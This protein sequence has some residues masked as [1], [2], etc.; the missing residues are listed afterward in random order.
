MTIVNPFTGNT[1]NDPWYDS[2]EV[3]PINPSYIKICCNLMDQNNSLIYKDPLTFQMKSI[4]PNDVNTRQIY[5][6]VDKDL[7]Y[8]NVFGGAYVIPPPRPV[9]STARELEYQQMFNTQN[10]KIMNKNNLNNL[11]S[12]I[13][14][15]YPYGLPLGIGSVKIEPKKV[16]DNTELTPI[17]AD[18]NTLLLSS[19]EFDEAYDNGDIYTDDDGNYFEVD[20]D[21]PVRIRGTIRLNNFVNKKRWIHVDGYYWPVKKINVSPIDNCPNVAGYAMYTDENNNEVKNV[22]VKNLNNIGVFNL[23]DNEILKAIIKHG[24]AVILNTKES[25]EIFGKQLVKKRMMISEKNIGGYEIANIIPNYTC[26]KDGIVRDIIILKG[27]L[28]YK[29]C[30]SDIKIVFPFANSV[31]KGIIPAKDKTLKVGIKAKIINDKNL[32]IGKGEIVTIISIKDNYYANSD[33]NQHKV[34]TVADKGGNRFKVW[35][36]C[37]KVI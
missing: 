8:R 12:K 25:S 34:V 36:N 17:D 6:I 33:I 16:I 29:F 7:F 14:K 13:F 20:T 15:D 11:I 23:S 26:V 10:V 27:D 9:V 4:Q 37:L 24:K 35:S 3:S 30:L 32:K 21:R 19:L 1:I 18:D 28:N 22:F 2:I 5:V 31:L